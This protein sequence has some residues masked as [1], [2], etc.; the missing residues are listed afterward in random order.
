MRWSIDGSWTVE[1]AELERARLESREVGSPPRWWCLSGGEP[2]TRSR[3]AVRAG[4]AP[5]APRLRLR[6]A[7]EVERLTRGLWSPP[8]TSP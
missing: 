6:D 8:G 7:D 3:D 5:A 2:A 4:S 1:S